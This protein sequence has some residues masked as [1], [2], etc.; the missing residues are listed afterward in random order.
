ML[1]AVKKEFFGSLDLTKEMTEM[2]DLTNI[3][4]IKYF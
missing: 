2:Y 1:F 3:S 4:I